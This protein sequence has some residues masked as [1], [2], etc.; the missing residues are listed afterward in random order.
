MLVVLAEDQTSIADLIVQR[1]TTA[2][3]RTQKTT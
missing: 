2:P 1:T 3:P